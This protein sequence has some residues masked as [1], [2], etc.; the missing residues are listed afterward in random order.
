MAVAAGGVEAR[1]RAAR[2]ARR[3]ETVAVG[4]ER[5]QRQQH[6]R[7]SFVH[8]VARRRTDLDAAVGGYPELHVG[9][10]LALEDDGA[11]AAVDAPAADALRGLLVRF[12]RGGRYRHPLGD[13]VVDP[14]CVRWR[15]PSPRRG[16]RRR[17]PPR[18]S[19]R[20]RCRSPASATLPSISPPA[21]TVTVEA[22]PASRASTAP[23]TMPS[24]V[25]LQARRF[26]PG[27]RCGG[28]AR[29][30]R[31]Q[32]RLCRRQPRPCRPREHATCL[33]R[34]PATAMNSTPSDIPP[35]DT[36]SDCHRQPMRAAAA[37]DDVARQRVRDRNRQASPGPRSSD[38]LPT[39]IAVHRHRQVAG[40]RYAHRRT[41]GEVR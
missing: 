6:R 29:L 22:A 33:P 40:R 7:Q 39:T 24:T 14:R 10:A 34:R 16:A 41:P 1:E 31:P 27:P 15:P 32:A 2:R 11:A 4:G 38:T 9:A 3:G 21:P 12:A 28:P 18:C 37:A 17:F 19:P 26:R 30:P 8:A 5:V 36:A 20:P 23:S 25:M 35:E 13:N